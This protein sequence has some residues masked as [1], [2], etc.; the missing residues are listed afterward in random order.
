MFRKTMVLVGMAAAAVALYVPAVA[1]ADWSAGT[2]KIETGVSV[3]WVGSFAFVGA[4][5]G[6]SCSSVHSEWTLEPGTTGKVLSFDPTN[7][8][9]TTSGG[10]AGC[11]VTAVN[12]TGAWIT[13]TNGSD[14]TITIARLDYLNHGAFCPRH[15]LQ[16]EGTTTATPNDTHA[17]T[18]VTL[19]GAVGAYDG[20]T[21]A[22]IQN[23]TSSGT[24]AYPPPGPYGV[25]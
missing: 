20:T 12:A 22:L 1:P 16:L 19:T 10:L 13:H 18:K 9:C 3:P 25:T 4:L 15:N 11:T 5:G 21:E 6:V 14:I 17:M 23:V 24:L 2:S 7:T 8:S